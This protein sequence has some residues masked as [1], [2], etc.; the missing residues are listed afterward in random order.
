ME[1]LLNAI[2]FVLAFAAMALWLS[3]C[4]AVGG[5]TFCGFS[6]P[7]AR[8]S[9]KAGSSKFLMHK[10]RSARWLTHTAR[11]LVAVGCVLVLLFP[12]I[13]MTDDLHAQ[14]TAMEDASAT[15]KKV[16]Q[17]AAGHWSIVNLS[18]P[19][20]VMLTPFSYRLS[21]RVLSLIHAGQFS[22]IAVPVSFPPSGRSPPSFP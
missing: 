9:W 6:R 21:W 10:G 14:E 15:S 5:R 22:R 4:L 8:E 17:S 13:S 18:H 12:V 19:A 2:W 11:G 20:A 7:P 16:L 1:L 3:V